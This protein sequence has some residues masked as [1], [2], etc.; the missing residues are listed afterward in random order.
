ME[1]EIQ[2]FSMLP[3]VALQRPIIH[4][5]LI[6][7]IQL[8]IIETCGFQINFIVK[9]SKRKNMSKF[10]DSTWSMKYQLKVDKSPQTGVLCFNYLSK[11]EVKVEISC[12]MVYVVKPTRD[13]CWTICYFFL[14]RDVERLNNNIEFEHQLYR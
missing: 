6:A 7:F 9:V 11:L 10:D 5:V 13:N 2:S 4:L 8:K 1:K 3:E 12:S 14:I